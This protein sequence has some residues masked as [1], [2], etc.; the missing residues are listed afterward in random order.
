MKTILLISL[1]FFSFSVIAADFKEMLMKAAQD[2]ANQEK[3]K[4]LVKKGVDHFKEKKET[5]PDESK[6][7][8][9]KK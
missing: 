7:E 2:K 1:S 5:P 8:T 9:L 3:A 6:D 4:E